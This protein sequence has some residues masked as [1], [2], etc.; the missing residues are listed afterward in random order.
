M[1]TDGVVAVASPDEAGIAIRDA[2]STA[3]AGFGV[4]SL[5]VFSLS[6]R[7][8]KRRLEK[9]EAISVKEEKESATRKRS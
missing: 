3:I 4:T 7:R 2:F 9:L 1:S 5:I 8:A 6:A